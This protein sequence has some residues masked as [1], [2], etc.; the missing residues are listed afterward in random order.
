MVGMINLGLAALL[1]CAAPATA[2]ESPLDA[3][4]IKHGL[5]ALSRA[6]IL[7]GSIEIESSGFRKTGDDARVRRQD[8][9]HLGSCTK[10]M[11]ATLAAIFVEREALR[12][13]EPLA[14]LLPSMKLHPAFEKVTLEMLL[15]HRSGLAGDVPAFDGGKLWAKLWE[16][17]LDPSEGRR[18]LAEKMLGAAPDSAPGSRYEYSNANYII[19]GAVLERVSGLSWEAVIQKELFLPLKMRC[20]FG[21]AADPRARVPDQPWGHVR[22]G[23]VWSPVHGD[24]PPPVGPAGTVHCS[25]ADWSKFARLHLDGGAGRPTVLLGPKSFAKLHA[26]YPGQEYT[27]GGWLRLSRPW[28]GKSGAALMHMGS[29]TMN[30]AVIW[31]A[32]ERG[33]GVLAAANA[34]GEGASRAVDEGVGTLIEA[35]SR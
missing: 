8:R 20:G 34:A 28:A 30:T 32:P 35:S 24:N 19:V 15:A 33:L 23:E 17:G 11:T 10:A 18:L 6:L 2:S 7:D 14:E 25:L 3:I 31:L 9:F 1:L 21:P 13:D 29:N 22:K 12:W 26:A 4:R 27:Y 16:P 5:P